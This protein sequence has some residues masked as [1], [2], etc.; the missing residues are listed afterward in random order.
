[1]PN[2]RSFLHFLSRLRNRSPRPRLLDFIQQREYA[3]AD[4]SQFMRFR[5]GISV[6]PVHVVVR[7]CVSAEEVGTR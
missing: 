5:A 7:S 4:P 6:R 3:S 1:M 2:P